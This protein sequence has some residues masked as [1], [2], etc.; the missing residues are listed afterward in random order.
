MKQVLCCVLCGVL[1]V[2]LAGVA[3]ANK[4][5]DEN[6]P[7]IMASPSTIVAAKVDTVT[8]HTNIPAATVE[9]GSLALNGIAP[10][11]VGVDNCGHVV[12]RF[13]VADLELEPGEAVLTLTGIA[14][15]AP[16]I[17]SDVVTVK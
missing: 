1:A 8:V 2:G 6:G 11:G 17:A 13:A 5:V 10:T 4:A 12:A 15:G 14:G 9:P 7:A 3:A 16:F